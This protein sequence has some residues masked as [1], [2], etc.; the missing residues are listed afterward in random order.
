MARAALWAIIE[1]I[2]KSL[3]LDRCPLP[4]RLI[5]TTPQDHVLSLRL[6]GELSHDKSWAQ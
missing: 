6:Y 1:H 5:R 2:L 4:T 3:A